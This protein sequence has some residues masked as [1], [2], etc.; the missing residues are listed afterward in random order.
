MEVCLS[1]YKVNFYTKESNNGYWNYFKKFNEIKLIVVEPYVCINFIINRHNN[2]IEK[3]IA[4]TF[5]N[6]GK[7]KQIIP[8]YFY[9]ENEFSWEN[10]L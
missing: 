7:L 1:K 4:D 10:Y 9:T 5:T 2:K 6:R 8:A 3:D